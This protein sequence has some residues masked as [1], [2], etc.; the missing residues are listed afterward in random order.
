MTAP[1]HGPHVLIC[2]WCGWRAH[3]M[4]DTSVER[5]LAQHVQ[6][7]ELSIPCYYCGSG[8][9]VRCTTSSGKP[10]PFHEGRRRYA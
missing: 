4:G 6:T 7:C 2:R 9:R 8:Q 5:V 1:V 3:R 10:A